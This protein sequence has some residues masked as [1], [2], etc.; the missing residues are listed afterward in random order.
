MYFG[1]TLGNLYAEFSQAL[2]RY[3]HNLLATG[4]LSESLQNTLLNH[5]GVSPWTQE[6][7]WPLQVYPR[8]LAALAQVSFPSST[9]NDN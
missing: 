1:A 2:S 6:S 8:T 3:T 5:L 7:N 9:I 4:L